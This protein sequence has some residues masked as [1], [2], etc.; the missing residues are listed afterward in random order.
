VYNWHEIERDWLLG[1]KLA[2]A[3]DQVL[4]AFNLVEAQ[5]GRGWIEATRVHGGTITRG[6]SPTLYVVMLGQLLESLGSA[7]NAGHLLDKVRDGLPDAR[8]ELV[9][10]HLVRAGVPDLEL[11]IEPAVIVGSR[12]R[13]PDFRVRK[14]GQ[15][16]TYAEVTQANISRA[17]ADVRGSME[18]I[19]GLVD[20]LT[21]T[22]A[23]E[24]FL[25]REP[26][27]DEVDLISAQI[28][29]R[30]GEARTEQTDLE[31]GLGTLY[32]NAEAP[33]TLTLNDHGE[34][35]APRLGL[36]RVAAVGADKRQIAVRWPFTDAR[37]QAFLDSE[38]KQLPK[39]APGLIMIQT[40]GAVGA[41]KAWR[42]L[43]ERRFQPT[44][45]TRVSAVCLFSSGQW[46]TQDGE[47]WRPQTKLIPNPHARFALPAWLSEQLRR[48]QS[49]EPDLPR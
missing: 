25:K 4:H 12:N 45:Y 35:Y 33:G 26:T 3:N 37:A 47:E 27:P 32:W 48:F 44:I 9:A 2:L 41:M 24:V 23:V 7:P 1:G 43:I 39:D 46:L 21:G 31:G 6:T 13:K 15:D 36:S 40:A 8:A 18:W 19:A 20:T 34:G 38:T 17:Q 16:W 22:F 42:A 14:A 29:D 28:K 5:F 10:I 11:E 49:D 30:H